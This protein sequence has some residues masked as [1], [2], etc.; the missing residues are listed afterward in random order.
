MSGNYYFKWLTLSCLT[1]MLLAGVFN[2]IIDPYN[3]FQSITLQGVNTSKPVTG[4]RAGLAKTYMINK[5]KAKTLFIGASKFDVGLDPESIYLPASDKPAFNLAVPGAGVYRQ[6]R[7]I[8]HAGSINKPNMI[9]MSLE[10]EL[11]L[12]QDKNLKAY[13]PT[14]E[15]QVWEKRL[16]VNYSGKLNEEKSIQFLKDIFS[17]LLSNTAIYDSIKTILSGDK[18]W[19]EPTGLSSGSARFSS[20]VNNKGHFSVFRDTINKQI[21][22][23]IGA[24]VHPDSHSFKALEDIINYCHK[25]NIKLI[26]ILPPYHSFQ[27]ELW[28][29]TNLW[30][31]FES[32]KKLIVRKIDSMDPAGNNVSIWDFATYNNMTTEH[33]PPPFNTTIKMQWYW[34][35]A[36]F[37]ASLGDRIL[38]DIF[39][40]TKSKFGVKLSPNT[41]CAHLNNNRQQQYLYRSNSS[42][43]LDLFKLIISEH[44]TSEKSN[45][46]IQNKSSCSF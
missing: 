30:L 44:V 10:F 21:K 27:Y 11:F 15:P 20:E 35:P 34:E 5:S 31:E 24:K 33:V 37:K 43:Q 16:N 29:K 32:W 46:T 2:Y 3:I 40:S 45:D 14:V 18:T 6:Y 23:L 26:L 17:S 7:Y 4:N 41:I 28:D 25:R 9:L 12:F 42:E 39:T 19:I 13:P 38:S 8:Q 36:H 1:V 22:G